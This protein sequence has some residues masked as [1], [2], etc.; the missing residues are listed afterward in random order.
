[1]NLSNIFS[2]KALTKIEFDCAITKRGVE[3]MYCSVYSKENVQ[4]LWWRHD[5]V[6]HKKILLYY[7]RFFFD[8][9]INKK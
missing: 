1:M 5:D 3:T 9:K 7:I 6:V 2:G 8:D 4:C